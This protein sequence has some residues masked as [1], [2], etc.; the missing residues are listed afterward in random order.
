MSA[1][2][3]LSRPQETKA[4]SNRAF[5]WVFTVAFAVIAIWPLVSHGAVRWWALAVSA[6]FLVVTLFAPALLAFPNKLWMRFGAL[7]HRV[8]SPVVVGFLF[9]VVVTP[10]GMLMR[11]LSKKD[12]RWRRGGSANSYWIRREPPGPAPDSLN[13]QF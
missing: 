6:V 5:G 7:L 9:Y 2:E 12:M 10:M 13:N 1:H 3:N 11:A 8:V 4:S